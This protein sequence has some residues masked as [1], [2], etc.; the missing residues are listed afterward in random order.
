MYDDLYSHLPTQ[1][2]MFLPITQYHSGGEEANFEG[3]NKACKLLLKNSGIKYAGWCCID[4]CISVLLKF[5]FPLSS[6]L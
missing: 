3:D 5:R 2:W 1:G 4:V 6:K